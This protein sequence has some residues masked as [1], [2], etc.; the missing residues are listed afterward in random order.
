MPVIKEIDQLPRFF[1]HKDSKINIK[2]SHLLHK[3]KLLQK[4]IIN[5]DF[6]QNQII[7]DDFAHKHK[8]INKLE[9]ERFFYRSLLNK[10]SKRQKN[11]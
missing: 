10:L 7:I 4:E 6:Q 2:E 5:S 1:S 3:N 8:T 11:G 9:Q